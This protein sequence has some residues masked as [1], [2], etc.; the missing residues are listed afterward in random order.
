MLLMLAKWKDAMNNLLGKTIYYVADISYLAYKNF[1][2]GN[3]AYFILNW[4]V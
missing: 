3:N 2:E 4:N 1:S